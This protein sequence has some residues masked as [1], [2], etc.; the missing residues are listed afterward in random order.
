MVRAASATPSGGQRTL[1]A[2]PY[3]RADAAWYDSGAPEATEP[4]SECPDATG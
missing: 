3:E 2:A 4:P 1:A